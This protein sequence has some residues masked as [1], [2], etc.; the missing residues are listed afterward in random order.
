MSRQE[1]VLEEGRYGTP[2]PLSP[3]SGFNPVGASEMPSAYNAQ[4]GYY[5][6][7]YDRAPQEVPYTPSGPQFVSSGQFH[8]KPPPLAPAP[9]VGAHVAGAGAGAA[10]GMGIPAKEKR[11]CGLRRKIFFIILGVVIVLII[12]G[13]AAGLAI[14][15]TRKNNDG[16][17]NSQAGGTGAGSSTSPENQPPPTSSEDDVFGPSIGP[18][19][20]PV[21][22]EEP[23]TTSTGPT[24][25]PPSDGL[26]TTRPPT[27]TTSR[28]TSSPT[29][30]VF[31]LETGYNTMALT[32][33]STTGNRDLCS[34]LL[35]AIPSTTTI[36]PS[37]AGNA[38][39]LYTAYW[40]LSNNPG[41]LS[42]TGVPPEPTDR[43]QLWTFDVPIRSTSGGCV[44]DGGD[45]IGLEKNG[46]A[47]YTS[48]FEFGSQCTV[49]GIR[50]GIGD[51]CYV[52]WIGYYYS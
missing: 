20:E 10:M 27:R 9:F 31:T 17:G 46:V 34:L 23:I 7:H 18:P 47:I 5:A 4:S 28:R 29:I 43:Y 6:G 11:I 40:Q 8:D 51:F 19:T 16:S 36:Y 24:S 44:Q 13:L 49:G 45:G 48:G 32:V 33:T 21:T 50:F 35:E 25:T 12:A 30:S 52:Y 3:Q 37:I 15:L 1:G 22:S 14:A 38:E 39:D 26:I 42:A 2:A 41:T